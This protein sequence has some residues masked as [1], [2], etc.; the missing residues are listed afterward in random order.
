MVGATAVS[1][2][3]AQQ[4]IGRSQS[5]GRPVVVDP[6]GRDYT[7]YRGATVVK[8]NALEMANVVDQALITDAEFQDASQRLATVLEG[9]AL[10]VTRGAQGMYVYQPGSEPVT[11]HSTAQQV[12]DVTGA[13]DT[14]TSALAL[15]RSGL[16]SHSDPTAPS[17][18]QFFRGHGLPSIRSCTTL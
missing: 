15:N 11:I 5:R 9:S 17:V 13:G 3:L 18:P 6:K 4:V 7:R 10:V 8:P 14:V 2:A 16:G 12:F 1:E